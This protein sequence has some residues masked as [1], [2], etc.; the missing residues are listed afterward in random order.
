MQRLMTQEQIHSEIFI[1]YQQPKYTKKIYYLYIERGFWAHSYLYK[2]L[3]IFMG[4]LLFGGLAACMLATISVLDSRF[5]G[6][7]CVCLVEQAPSM[8]AKLVISY[9][10]RVRLDGLISAV[11][12][13][14]R[15]NSQ[16]SLCVAY[17]SRDIRLYRI[18]LKVCQGNI[19]YSNLCI[20]V[21]L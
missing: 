9:L 5:R 20:L 18:Q 6:Y 4:T 19:S 11:Y 21:E 13:F 3:S 2:K 14:G 15:L 17:S 16:W 12:V 1:R 8:L 7:S 10:M